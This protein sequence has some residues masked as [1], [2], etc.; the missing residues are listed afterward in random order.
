MDVGYV[1]DASKYSRV[2]R[3][4]RVVFGEVVDVF[5]DAETQFADDPAGHWSRAMAIGQTR[6]GRILQVIFS[7]EEAPLVRV[8]T[9]F[10]ASKERRDEYLER[11][12]A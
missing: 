12:R 3:R 8:I 11:R 4:H 2:K 7:E 6:S 1:W 5:E 9:A 10:E